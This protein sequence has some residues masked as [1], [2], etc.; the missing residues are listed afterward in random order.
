MGLDRAPVRDGS[1]L[2][3]PYCKQ[4]ATAMERSIVVASAIRLV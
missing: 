3:Q 4:K 1:Q 2:I